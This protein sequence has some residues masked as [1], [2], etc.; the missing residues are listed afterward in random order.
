MQDEERRRIA[1]LLHDTTGQNLGAL[2]IGLSMILANAGLDASA[3]K[4]IEENVAL[5]D[6]CVREIRDLSK[7]LHPP[8]LDELGLL[9]ALRA[10]CDD[11]TE[12]DLPLHLPRLPPAIEIGLFRII[13]EGLANIGETAIL[14]LK[15]E[16]GKVE[17]ELT[18]RGREIS[19]FGIAIMRERA[20]QLGGM[21]TVVPS[22]TCM[23]I[24][25][26][27]PALHSQQLDASVGSS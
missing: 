7:L 21:L 15:Y 22:E 13:Q 5:A 9:S 8:L 10:Y 20:R 18:S 6:C 2:S 25:V 24:R 1:R 3:R 19:S 4:A 17:I 26:S 11:Y 16:S 23:T 14:R 12:L 27:V